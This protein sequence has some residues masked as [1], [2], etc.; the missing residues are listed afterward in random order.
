MTLIFKILGIALL[1][2]VFLPATPEPGFT[3]ITTWPA[4]CLSGLFSYCS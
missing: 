3:G 1:H 2:L 4:P